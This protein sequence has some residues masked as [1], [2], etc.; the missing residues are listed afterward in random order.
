M[1]NEKMTEALAY[2]G[3]LAPASVSAGAVTIG[4]VTMAKLGRILFVI[5]VGSVGAAGT[6]DGKLQAA[7][8]SG[9]TYSDVAGTT[10]TQVTATGVVTIEVKAETL[11]AASQGPYVKFVGTVGTNAV[12]MGGEIF[13]NTPCYRP[14]SDANTTTLQQIAV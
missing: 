8:T 10:I 4:P 14:A 2:L 13:A 6:L 7:A 11:A 12:V 5:N 3:R 9:G 1:Y